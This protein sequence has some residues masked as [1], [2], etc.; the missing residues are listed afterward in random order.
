[1]HIQN[2]TVDVDPDQDEGYISY[3]GTVTAECMRGYTFNQITL[4]PVTV[5]LGE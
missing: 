4:E 3:G 5:D 1:M 2:N